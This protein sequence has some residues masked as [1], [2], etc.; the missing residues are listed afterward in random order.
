ME[1]FFEGGREGLTNVAWGLTTMRK[2]CYLIKR[3]ST[4]T[5]VKDKKVDF[6][7]VFYFL[8]NCLH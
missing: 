7:L 3:H 5:S 1:E 8:N 4:E 2:M 6:V